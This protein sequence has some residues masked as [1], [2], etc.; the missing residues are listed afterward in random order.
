MI[1]GQYRINFSIPKPSFGV[2]EHLKDMLD[3]SLIVMIDR[4]GLKQG[5]A[6]VVG[7]GTYSPVG[8]F[9]SFKDDVDISKKYLDDHG[10]SDEDDAWSLR[11]PESVGVPELISPFPS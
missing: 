7:G 3:L 5:L 8:P 1:P 11:I 10:A 6:F 2:Y 4:N 9:V